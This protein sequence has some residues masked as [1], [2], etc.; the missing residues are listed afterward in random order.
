MSDEWQF[1]SNGIANRLSISLCQYFVT[2]IRSVTSAVVWR[3]TQLYVA[4]I[5]TPAA[6]PQACSIL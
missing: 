2:L 4:D 3:F 5:I 1:P 6:Y